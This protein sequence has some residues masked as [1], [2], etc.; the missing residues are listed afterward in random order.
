MSKLKVVA[1]A[2]AMCVTGAFVLGPV[3]VPAHPARV[4]NDVTQIGVHGSNESGS[5]TFRGLMNVRRF[6]V[7]RDGS[8]RAVTR[9]TSGTVRNRQGDVVRRLADP[10]RAVFPVGGVEVQQEPGGPRCDILRL[11]LGPLDLDLLGLVIHLDRVVLTI[12]AVPG[13]GNLLGNLLCAIAGLLDRQSNL[14]R[15]LADIL[16]AILVVLRNQ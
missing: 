8:L 1:I 11:T 15:V 3:S 9:I 16:N 5:R 13:P 7:G 12:D 4:T 10:V 14:N 2:T 6:K